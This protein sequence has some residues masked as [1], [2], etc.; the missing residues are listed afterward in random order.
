MINRRP[1]R[2]I[3]PGAYTFL[4]I[5]LFPAGLTPETRADECTGTITNP[6]SITRRFSALTW[7]Q[8]IGY[9][10]EFPDFW[11]G[12]R[13]NGEGFRESHLAF[14]APSRE[15]VQAFF[16]AVVAG[17]AEVLHAPRTFH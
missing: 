12:G 6:C 16:D 17:G 3:L 2:L 8:V 7:L 1:R 13:E 10:T 11:L 9:G 15:A 4:G 14:V 5:C